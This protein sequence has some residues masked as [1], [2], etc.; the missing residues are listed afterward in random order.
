MGSPKRTTVSGDE[1]KQRIVAAT[2]ATLKSEGI[3]GTS[4]RVIAKAGDFNQAL[5]FYHFGSVDEAILASVAHMS[6]QRM[7][8]H[9]VRLEAATTFPE[10]ISIARSLHHDDSSDG[11]M[12]VLTQ[13]LAGSV[14]SPDLGPKLYQILDPWSDLVAETVS[15]V[16]GDTPVARA[17]PHQSIARTINALFLGIE[18]LDDLDPSQQSAESLFDMLEGM[19]NV[20]QSMMSMPLVASAFADASPD[21]ETDS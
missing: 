2:L 12:T 20:V 8:R 13:T 6:S 21:I 5:I 10:L 15:R 16:L 7:E 4:A 17:V 11:S 18:L 9:R 14:R 19:A 1:T 3:V